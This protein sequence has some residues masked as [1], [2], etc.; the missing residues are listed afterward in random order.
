[1]STTSYIGIEQIDGTVSVVYSHHN[2]HIAGVGS[3]LH[4][5]YNTHDAA[6]ELVSG[7]DMTFPGASY[8]SQGEC[9]ADTA[10]SINQNRGH[11]A[12]QY[13]KQ[14][15]YLYCIQTQSWA[16]MAPGEQHVWLGLRHA[17]LPARKN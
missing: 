1:M 15:R 3:A 2:G 4:N 8:S 12:V 6:V 9:L 5:N 10:P 16:V 7:G 13:K 11:F 17:L 14:Y